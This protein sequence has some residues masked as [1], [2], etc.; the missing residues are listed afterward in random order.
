MNG[1]II[2]INV[3]KVKVHLGNFVR[4]TASRKPLSSKRK[5]MSCSIARTEFQTPSLSS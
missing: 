4:E 5:S 1:K 3:E 2:E